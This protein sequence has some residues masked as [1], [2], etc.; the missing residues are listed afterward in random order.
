MSLTN[1]STAIIAIGAGNLLGSLFG[2]Q[3]VKNLVYKELLK[4]NYLH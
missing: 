4:L 3:L 2:S 1:I